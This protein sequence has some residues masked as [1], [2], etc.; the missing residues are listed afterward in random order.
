MDN[1]DNK[2]III[3]ILTTIIAALL[4]IIIL[5][6][7]QK[8]KIKRIK[9]QL[10]KLE[11]EKN[12]LDSSPVIPELSK[13]ESINRNEKLE[14]MYE[15][16]KNRLNEIRTEQIPKITD[17][18]LEVDYSL[19]KMDHKTAAYKMAKLEMEMYK[20]RTNSDFLLKEIREITTS[21]ERNRNIITTL[22]TKYRKLFD[23]FNQAKS[24][25]GEI[26]EPIELQFENI[27]KRFEIFESAMEQNEYTEVPAITTSIDD[28]LK[29]M[30]IVVNE[31]PSIVLLSKTILPKKIK[32]VEEEY[33]KLCSEGYPLDYLNVEYNI[34]EAN[35]KLVDIM[36]RSSVLNLENSLVELKVLLDYFE[37][38]FT[39]FD[40]EKI[41]RREYEESCKIYTQK[42]NKTN[43]I[44]TEIFNQLD[45]IKRLY[46]LSDDSIKALN[47]IKD[48]LDKANDDYK[49]LVEHTSNNTFAY[50]KLVKE[51]ETI[52]I[53]YS[54]I[55]ERLDLVLDSIG[56]MKDD[57]SRAR[58]QLEEIK[59]ILKDARNQTR[60]YNLPVIPQSYIV[61]LNDAQLAIKEIM[62][63]LDKK[64]I[65]IEVL[66][67]RVDTARDLVLK[68]YGTTKKMMRLA[69]FAEMAVVY[70]NRYRTMDLELDRNLT[71][72]EKL[73]FEGEYQKSL[74]ISINS[75]N[76]IEPGIYDK[77]LNLYSK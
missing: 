1:I 71:H 41:A 75:L 38:L 29:H 30:E 60:E 45:E 33:N 48:E 3:F 55:E 54:S 72:A 25:F 74:E 73:Y 63:E 8:R 2:V 22:K 57:E 69:S 46:N 5:N 47:E 35:K 44:V 43:K 67:T 77:L 9:K 13:I 76:K 59:G 56:N 68:V 64:P 7:I 50:S 49:I 65:T 18:L 10:D 66:N 62:K 24:D 31:I 11:V 52:I 17:M 37:N 6:A 26:A 16:W 58:Q 27:A 12:M 28:M 39:E 20:V 34:E 42:F 4:I 23:K 40:K 36:D 53:R 32:D 14:A 21:D 61:E 70:G 19:S 15:N 51:I